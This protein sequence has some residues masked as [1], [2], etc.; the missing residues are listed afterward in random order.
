MKGP[1]KPVSAVSRRAATGL[2]LASVALIGLDLS[3]HWHGKSR[4]ARGAIAVQW[5]GAATV[6]A[7]PGVLPV[8]I[9]I[10]V[11]LAVLLWLGHH[12]PTPLVALIATPQRRHGSVF[13]AATLRRRHGLSYRNGG[14]Y[15]P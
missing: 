5:S 4:H 8:G 9:T 12:S 15:G 14:R 10:V 13:P 3:A 1:P 6:A 2:L 7:H 11:T